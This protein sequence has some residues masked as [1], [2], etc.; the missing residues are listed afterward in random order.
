MKIPKRIFPIVIIAL[1]ITGCKE[2]AFVKEGFLFDTYVSV[3]SEG[4]G[5]EAA[6]MT[7]YDA[8]KEIDGEFSKTF[9]IPAN[10]LDDP[11]SH[12]SSCLIKTAEISHSYDP[13]GII[14]PTCGALTSLWKRGSVPDG[15]DIE[16]ALAA[17]GGYGG[18]DLKEFPDGVFF[19][20]GAVAK[21]YALDIIKSRLDGKSYG[22]YSVI[23]TGSSILLY[24]EKPEGA[25]FSTAV[26]NPENPDEY[27]GYIKTKAAFIST[28]GGYERF[29]EENGEKY[30][31]I[32][33]L[34]TG[35]PAET[36]LASVTVIVPAETENGG[37][38]SDYL[39]TLIYIGGT[40]TL[41][42]YL[43]MPETSVI[44]VDCKGKIT[45]SDF[46]TFDGIL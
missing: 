19:D 1:I 22:G 29:F 16:A 30:S 44:A 27:L 41:E 13:G 35:Y 5:A 36:D 8:M 23:S 25:A 3:K 33:D 7:A 26:R 12:L 18:A 11:L 21:G 34:K 15:A 24:G 17:L 4:P 14:N 42:K 2:K 6:A 28:S 43:N 9:D 46:L 32:I 40:E 20:F 31:H 45:Y 37:L 38:L 10:K 39:S